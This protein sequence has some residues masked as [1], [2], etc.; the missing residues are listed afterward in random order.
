MRLLSLAVE[1]LG[2]YRGQ[3]HFD[4]A[5]ATG[6]ADGEERPL[7]VISGRNGSGKSTLFQ[8]LSLA[9]HG[10]LALGDRV[11][12]E[13][14]RKFLSG[15]LHRGQGE[16]GTSDSSGEG[17]VT[18]AFRYVRSGRPVR[19]EVERRWRRAGRTGYGIDETLSVLEDGSPPDVDESDYQT[20]LNDFVPPGLTPLCFF[21][22]ERLDALA[23]PE[24]HDGLLRDIFARLLGLDLVG[25]LQDDLKSYT[26][27]R[28]GRQATDRLGKEVLQHQAD[29]EVLKAGLEQLAAASA[30]LDEEQ[31][32]LE[33]TLAKQ[34]GHLASEGGGYAARRATSQE[35]LE[36][37]RAEIEGVS[38]QLRE[39][40]AD[41]LPFALAPGLCRSLDARLAQEA[42]AHRQHL[43]GQLWRERVARVESSLQ[44]D[45]LWEGSGVPADAR[46]TMAQRIAN[47]LREMGEASELDGQAPVHS[48]SEQEHAQ[49]QGWIDQALGPASQEAQS[50]SQR[51]R[52]LGAEQKE[53]EKDLGRAPDDEVLAPLRE[54]IARSEAALE[55]ARRRRA[56]LTERTGA[57]R[58]QLEEKERQLQ[59]AA[60]QLYAAQ[61]DERRL[62]LA[63]RSKRALRA[64]EDALARRELSALED[65]LVMA[66]NTIC[67]KEHLLTGVSIDPDNL[68]VELRGASGRAL[69]LGDFSAGERQ[70]YVMSLLWALRR[71]S[72]RQLPLAVDTPLARLDEMHRTRLL[73]DYVPAVSDQVLLFVTDAELDEGLLAEAEPYLSRVYR[74]EYDP[75]EETTVVNR[76]DG[77]ESP[78]VVLYRRYDASEAH[79]NGGGENVQVW[80]TDL[81]KVGTNGDATKALLPKDA[82][83]MVLFHPTTKEHD[84]TRVAELERIVDAPYISSKLRAGAWI[85][86]LWQEDWTQRLRQAGRDSVAVESPEGSAEYV[87]NPSALLPL[88]EPASVEDARES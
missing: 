28:G 44:G 54:D 10:S 50:L 87:L 48:L 5:P 64:Y 60:E 15:R 4:L 9:L 20:W 31:A 52:E 26:L 42:E 70:L 74:L 88:T 78:G 56:E 55:E 22:A 16:D 84:W 34:E 24:Q 46:G 72:G 83:R 38:E 8:A 53:I 21:D 66:F 19:I 6:R 2:V 81:A 82:K 80:T 45:G 14:Y 25:R 11:S 67:R 17:G 23:T 76:T 51:L 29:V 39:L 77:P 59:R 30:S 73:H 85:H 13:A 35:K 27:G 32:E 18:L 36:A 33:A 49:L 37:V 43:A 61:A 69:D 47:L 3:H 75:D 41:L 65:E 40:S 71:V 79:A 57:L 62:A 1:N 12:R 68:H 63:E 7:V 58:F 86:E